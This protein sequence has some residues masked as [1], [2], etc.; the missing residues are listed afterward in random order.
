PKS[1]AAT[2]VFIGFSCPLF[3]GPGDALRTGSFQIMHTINNYSPIML[4]LQ[5]FAHDL[6]QFSSAF[7][8]ILF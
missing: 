1:M 8:T 6:L 7:V 5:V 2:V 4:Q 3:S